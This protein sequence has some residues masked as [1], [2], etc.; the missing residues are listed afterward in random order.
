MYPILLKIGPLT[1]YSFGV[2]MATGFYVG[3]WFAASEFRRR[4]GDP[5]PMWNLLLWTFLGGLAGARLLLLLG[6]PAA[7]LRD[8]IGELFSGSGFVWYGGLIGGM[9]V[10]LALFRRYRIALPTLLDCSALGLAI[11]QAIGRLGCHIAGDGDWGTVTRLPWGVAYE[12]AIVGWPHPPG[13]RVHPTPLYEAAA[14]TLVF[15]A[16]WRIRKKGFREGT[17]FALYLVGTSSARF[18]VEFVRLNPKIAW[19]LTE[20]QWTALALFTAA[21]TWLIRH[22]RALKPSSV[23]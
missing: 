20:A 3:A 19:G 13:V 11:G 12:R 7:V 14:Y 22:R 1:V 6:D 9:L 16:L 15:L 8:P 4:G 2:M 10:A 21:V 5:E 18:A 23:G 17:L